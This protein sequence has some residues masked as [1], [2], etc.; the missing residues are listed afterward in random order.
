[1]G[2]DRTRMR[3]NGWGWA[4]HKDDIAL[5]AGFWTWLASELGMPALL[6][7]PAR[8]FEELT[9]PAGRLEEADRMALGA[10]VGEENVCETPFERVFHALGRSYRDLLLVRAGDL[11]TAPDAAVYPRSTGEVLAVLALAAKRNIAVVPFGGGTSAAGGV[12]A[13]RG[14]FET[15]ITLDMSAMNRLIDIDPFSHTATAE[16][17]IGGPALEKALRARGYT[18]GR[19]P[20]TFEFST[21]GGWI[22]HGGAAEW[23]VSVKLATP[24]GLMST[25]EFPS[26]EAG[27]QL[28]TIAAGSEGIFGV[29]TEAA[30]RIH[31]LPHVTEARAWL[32]RDFASG[33]AAIR[34]AAQEGI[35]CA[36]LHLSDGDETRFVRACD[37]AGKPAGPL[38]WLGKRYLELR[39]Y[40]GSPCLL[41]A[42]FEG[43]ERAAASERK[44]F[45]ALARKY[46]ALPYWRS[47]AE[48]WQK[49]R[50]REPYLRDTL[51]DRGVGIDIFETAASWAKIDALHAAVR[52][53]LETAIGE[54]V[55]REDA[56][57]IVMSRLT[58]ASPQGASLRFTA[59]FP[60][61]LEGD[62][63]QWSRIKNAATAAIVSHGGTLSH[64]LGVG[65]DN[66][67]WIKQEKGQLGLDALR[68]IKAA[69]D[70]AGVM[71]PGKLIP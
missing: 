39:G 43:E 3:W 49:T 40:D 23:L 27:P 55:P 14:P 53:V 4:A 67:P 15:A 18:L 28:R 16:A 34:A 61:K 68:A 52:T 47:A 44:R 11:S 1:M 50:F 2:I 42:E 64:H 59:V 54:T 21:L 46:R 9:L 30:V 33:T 41:I 7:T 5:R 8:P 12:S 38:Q 29:I 48:Q 71:N 20:D 35:A 25:G 31:K 36:T 65:R 10:I 69:L 37:T 6:A 19:L 32:F 70:P 51:L 45:A 62:L 13:L 22:A 26:S 24:R 56:R 17:G 60:R 58:Y 57:G 66:L 63:E